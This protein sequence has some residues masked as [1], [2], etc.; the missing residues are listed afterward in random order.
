MQTYSHKFTYSVQL[1]FSNVQFQL[2]GSTASRSFIW[3]DF[4]LETVSQ[5]F[6]AWGKNI[7]LSWFFFKIEEIVLSC[8]CWFNNYTSLALFQLGQWPKR[9]VFIIMNHG[10]VLC[11]SWLLSDPFASVSLAYTIWLSINITKLPYSTSSFFCGCP[12]NRPLNPNKRNGKH[13][14]VSRK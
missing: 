14:E 11:L 13:C 4:L 9:G 10:G 5:G 6:W 12:I 3:D 2:K 7:C 1:I 8:S